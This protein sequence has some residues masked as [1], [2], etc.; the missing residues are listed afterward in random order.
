MRHASSKINNAPFAVL[1]RGLRWYDLA[2]LADMGVC[3]DEET[4]FV[5]SIPLVHMRHASTC[6][7]QAQIELDCHNVCLA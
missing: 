7:S 5:F 3:K 4:G 6:Q 1:K 2:D